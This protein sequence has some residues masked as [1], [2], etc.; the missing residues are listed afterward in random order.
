MNVLPASSVYDGGPRGVS[1]SCRG[2]G[3]LSV[4][5]G[6]AAR[7][8]SAWAEH[9]LQ[10]SA[11]TAAQPTLLFMYSVSAQRLADKLRGRRLDFAVDRTMAARR[12]RQRR[13]RGRRS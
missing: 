12:R 4:Q 6:T 8:E 9:P 1:D 3:G 7:P 5:Y 13:R 2:G 10:M 11:W